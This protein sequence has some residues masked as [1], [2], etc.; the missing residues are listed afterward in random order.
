MSPSVFD[1]AAPYLQAA[2]ARSEP[3]PTLDDVRAAV[4]DGKAMLWPGGSSAAVTQLVEYRAMHVWLVAGDRDELM[5]MEAAACELGRK[6]GCNVITAEDARP[7]W[8][9]I[10]KD[11][12]YREMRLLVKEI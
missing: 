10:L 3:G 7:G 2:L 9:R 1:H 6:L 12:G 11:M 5:Q 4:S 8:A